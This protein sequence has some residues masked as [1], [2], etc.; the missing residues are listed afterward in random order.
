[1]VT[2]EEIIGLCERQDVIQCTN[3]SVTVMT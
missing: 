2:F 1:V 3:K